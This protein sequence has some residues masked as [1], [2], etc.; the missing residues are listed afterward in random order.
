MFYR[1]DDEVTTVEF[2][3]INRHI[4]TAG[5]L[6]ASDCDLVGISADPIPFGCNAEIFDE[7]T[8]ISLCNAELTVKIL[9]KKEMLVVVDFS[10]G[11]LIRN[12][13]MKMLGRYSAVNISSAKLIFAF[14]S[15]L[16]EEN[17]R[18]LDEFGFEITALEETVLTDKADDKFNLK[19]LKMK[20][21]LLKTLGYYKQLHSVCDTVAEN[22]NEILTDDLGYIDNLTSRVER[23]KADIGALQD[24]VVHL[25]EAYSAYLDLQ[26]NRSMKIFNVITSIFFPLTVI[27]SWYGMNFKYIPELNYKYGYLMVIIASAVV[28]LIQIAIGKRRHWF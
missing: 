3:E 12:C 5:Y 15:E 23:I 17:S 7:K 14:L 28:I 6:T 24:A 8:V 11:C 18:L 25:Q 27:T 10:G 2:D 20:K 1:F 9:I 21:S 22:E 13:F 26:L 4:L 19:L 16:I